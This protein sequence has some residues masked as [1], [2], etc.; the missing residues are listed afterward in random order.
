MF[1]VIIP[2]GKFPAAVTAVFSGFQQVVD[3]GLVV[4]QQAC[5]MRTQGD[6]AGTG[7]GGKIEADFR[8]E[9][10]CLGQGIAQAQP[11]FGVGIKNLDG[12]PRHAGDDIAG[13]AGNAV[14]HVFYS[15]YDANDIDWKL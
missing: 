7:Q 6:N 15:G 3:Q 12:L 10:L 14:R 1:L 2:Q 5:R 9:G 11:A 8:I 13:F 4:A